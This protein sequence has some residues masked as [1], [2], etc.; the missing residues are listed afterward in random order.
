MSNN[1]LYSNYLSDKPQ[2]F[3]IMWDDEESRECGD[4][5]PRVRTT[6]D[7]TCQSLSKPGTSLAWTFY[8]DGVEIGGGNDTEWNTTCEGE[9]PFPITYVGTFSFFNLKGPTVFSLC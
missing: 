7:L 4:I 2:D 6:T 8:I 5:I 3:K 9:D 1:H